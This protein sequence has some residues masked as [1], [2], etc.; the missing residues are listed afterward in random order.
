ME[1]ASFYLNVDFWQNAR[2]G[3]RV[4]QQK[5]Q[6]IFSCLKSNISGKASWGNAVSGRRLIAEKAFPGLKFNLR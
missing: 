2:F 4:F 3:N 1:N 6:I 5:T